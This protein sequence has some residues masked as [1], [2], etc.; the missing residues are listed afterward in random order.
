MLKKKGGCINW[1]TLSGPYITG[2]DLPT[3]EGICGKFCLKKAA[4]TIKEPHHF[5]Y[6]LISLLPLRRRCR[7]IRTI[8]SS[9]LNHQVDPASGSAI[10]LQFPSEYLFDSEK[11]LSMNLQ[12]IALTVACAKICLGSDSTY[13]QNEE[14]PPDFFFNLLTYE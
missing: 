3:S 13:L 5:G 14:P 1:R 4:F 11:W 8:T 6:I 2:I 7:N 9:L 12:M 10:M